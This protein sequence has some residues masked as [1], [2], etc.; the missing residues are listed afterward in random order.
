M[1]RAAYPGLAFWVPMSAQAELM[2][3]SPID[4][5]IDMFEP[6]AVHSPIY[7]AELPVFIKYKLRLNSGNSYIN[8]VK[9]EMVSWVGNFKNWTVDAE[10]L[11]YTGR[12]HVESRCYCV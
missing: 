1:V 4:V 3:L 6:S 5:W 8:S 7:I 10:I 11:E 9:V 2:D 12:H